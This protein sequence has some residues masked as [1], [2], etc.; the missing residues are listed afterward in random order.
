MIQFDDENI[1]GFDSFWVFKTVID[2]AADQTLNNELLAI[3]ESLFL[4]FHL[5]AGADK[6]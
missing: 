5:V 1:Y 3:L 6:L 2:A 4:Q